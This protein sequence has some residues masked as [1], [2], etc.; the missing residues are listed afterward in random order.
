MSRDDGESH[1]RHQALINADGP[2]FLSPL[3]LQRE[4]EAWVGN[5]D[6]KREGDFREN[7]FMTSRY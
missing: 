4:D 5:N 3:E 1:E 7:G 6:E 2:A